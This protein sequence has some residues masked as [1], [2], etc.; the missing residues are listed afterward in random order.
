MPRRKTKVKSKRR[1]VVPAPSKA[2]VRQNKQPKKKKSL[3]A[4]IGSHVGDLVEQGARGLFRTI[5]GI[6]DYKI[7]RN[8]IL[9]AGDP[10]VLSQGTRTNIIRHREYISDVSGTTAFTNTSYGLNAGNNLLFPWLYAIAQ[11]YEQYVF[12]GCVMEFKSTSADALNSTNTALG[13]VIMATE[14]NVLNN[15]FTNKLG[16]ENHEFT[17]S[18]KPS[19]CMLHPIECAT[20]QTPTRV[21]YTR[22]VNNTL[23]NDLRFVDMGNFQIATVGMQASAVIGELWATYEVELLKPILTN[24][25]NNIS[26]SSVWNFTSTTT[27]AIFGS[28]VP[29]TS[30]GNASA[31]QSNM[32]FGTTSCILASTLLFPNSSIWCFIYDGNGTAV[33]PNIGVWTFTNANGVSLFDNGAGAASTRTNTLTGSSDTWVCCMAAFQVTG[34]PVILQSNGGQFPSSMSTSFTL[35]RLS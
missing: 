21:F 5:T 22:P 11:N 3:G 14:Y 18:C 13:T 7:E 24:G 29:T 19:E 33:A 23:N 6:G 15:P 12:H 30:Y 17:T 8:T 9:S 20:T 28:G 32:T 34:S 16:M 1:A 26:S 31:L 25:I 4:Q 10:P 35:L 27:T 2:P